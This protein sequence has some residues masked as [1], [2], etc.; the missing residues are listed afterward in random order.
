M[1]LIACI[2]FMN[3]STARS[4]KRTKEVGIRKAVGALPSRLVRQFLGEAMSVSLAATTAA[5]LTILA[6][7]P[8][9]NRLSG[10]SL[11]AGELATPGFLFSAAAIALA[12]GLVSGLYPALVLSSLRPGQALKAKSASS[13]SGVLFRRVLVVFQFTLSIEIIRATL[14]I[15]DQMRF[16]QTRDIGYDRIQI[17][18]MTLNKELRRNFESFRTELLASPAIENASTSSFIPTASSAH[19]VMN[20]E[21][22][23]RGQTQVVCYFIDP[24]FLRTYGINLLAGRMIT[25]PRPAIGLPSS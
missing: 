9:F 18:V 12:V 15:R 24:E 19:Y 21:G 5:V 23:N 16:I 20:F 6:V 13:R 10:K 14:V 22:G 3:L 25:G 8:L 17:L 1:L 2:N 4:A 7:L 11:S